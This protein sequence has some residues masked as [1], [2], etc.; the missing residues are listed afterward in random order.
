MQIEEEEDAYDPDDDPDWK[1]LK[2]KDLV[3][4]F[5]RKLE[6]LEEIRHLI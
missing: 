3:D 4:L 6:V 1:S 5:V 2:L